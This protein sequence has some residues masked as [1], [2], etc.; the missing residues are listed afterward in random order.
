VFINASG[1]ERMGLTI[2]EGLASGCR[3]LA[4]KYS[5]ALEW[6]PGIV[7]VDPFDLADLRLKLELAYTSEKWDY[8]PNAAARR[9][10]WGA[11]A[12]QYKRLYE[13]VLRG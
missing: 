11:L 5:R 1:S 4:T 2:I 8:T 6:F 9:L 13:E 10:T 3:V 12:W 7:K